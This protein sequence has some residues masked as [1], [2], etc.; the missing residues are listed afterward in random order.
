MALTA[1]LNRA[2][3]NPRSVR[4][5]AEVHLDKKGEGFE[6]TS[7]ELTTTVELSD[8][9]D[10]EFQTIAQETKKQCPV[11]KALAGTSITLKASLG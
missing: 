3:K 11:S 9:A 5:S 4:T 10:S 1:S 2:G 7:I 6:V 8:L